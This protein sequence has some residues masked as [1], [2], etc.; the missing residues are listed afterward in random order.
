MTVSVQWDDLDDET[1]DEFERIIL[2]DL[3]WWQIREIAEGHGYYEPDDID[4]EPY[5]AD[6]TW[7][8]NAFSHH[9]DN[10]HAEAMVHCL[11]PY[12]Q[13]DGKRVFHG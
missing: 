9:W 2:D 3:S 1:R 5:L 7:T 4:I 13:L 8:I 6:E 10:D 11:D 12:C